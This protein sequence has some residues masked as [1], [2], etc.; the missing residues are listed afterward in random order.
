[1]TWTNSMN[2]F[3]ERINDGELFVYNEESKKFYLQE[4]KKFKDKG[5]LIS[6][7]TEETLDKLV[8]AGSFKKHI[9]NPVVIAQHDVITDLILENKKLKAEIA[10]LKKD[11]MNVFYERINDGELFVYDEESKKFYL[12]EMKEFKDRGHLIS[13]YTEETL[14]KLVRAGSFKKHES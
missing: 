6:E 10:Q 2:T 11:R 7:Y 9:K 12:Q 14:D 1:M 13:E 5:H 3:Y 4:M 8:R